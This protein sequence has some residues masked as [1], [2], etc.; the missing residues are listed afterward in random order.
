MAH[1]QVEVV[2]KLGTFQGFI[3]LAANATME[4]A[5]ST[6]KQLIN[7][8]N[9]IESMSIESTDGTATVFPQTVLRESV[10]R[11]KAVE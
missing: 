10:V 6:L 7:G 2:N 9:S 5:T 1:I 8:I 3:T 11:A 4:D